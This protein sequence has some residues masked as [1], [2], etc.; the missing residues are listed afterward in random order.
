M[1]IIF[2]ALGISSAVYG[3]YCFLHANDPLNEIA[4]ILV[5]ILAAILVLGAFLLNT[6][7]RL[8]NTD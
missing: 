5:L 2:L 7:K 4:A 8:K 3:G 6:L 1:D